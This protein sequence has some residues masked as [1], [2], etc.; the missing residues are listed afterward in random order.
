MKT[1]I[2]RDN[3][4]PEKKIVFQCKA[5]NILEADLLYKEATG[6]DVVKQFYIGCEPQNDK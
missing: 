2:Y 6:K 4:T 1:Y 5:E 3:S